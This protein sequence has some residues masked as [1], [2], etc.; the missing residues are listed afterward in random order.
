M[1][2]DSP[3]DR[4]SWLPIG[5]VVVAAA[6]LGACG[7]GMAPAPDRRAETGATAIAPDPRFDDVRA[8]LERL[9]TEGGIPSVVVAVAKDGEIL[10]Q[11]GFGMA[12]R[13]RGI[14]ATADIPYS[15]A[16][17][18][19]AVTST[20]VMML[21]EQGRMD[22]DAPL[23]TYLGG[24]R[25]AGLAADTRGVTARRAMSHSAG[26]PPHFRMIYPGEEVPPPEQTLTRYGFV[27][28][29]P[30]TRFMYS[31]IGYRALDVAISNASGQPYGEFLRRQLFLPLGM[32][33][34]GLNL[35]VDP[36]WSSRVAARYDARREPLRPYTTDHPGSGDV[37]ASAHDVL[38][39]AMLHLGTLLPR[40]RALLKQE[41]LAEMH[42]VAGRPE[43]SWGLG[44]QLAVDRG[45]RV[46]E[47]GGGQPGVSTQLS[48]YPD[49]ELAI[50]VLSNVS[51]GH[52]YD[53]SRRIAAAVLPQPRQAAPASAPPAA[54]AAPRAPS[55]FAGTWDGT[56]TTLD[57][58]EPVVLV[59]QP[60]GDV[61]V[62]IGARLTSLVNNLRVS[63]DGLEGSFHGILDTRDTR[64]HPHTVGFTLWPA[65]DEITGLLTASV[66]DPL[67][68][69]SSFVRLHRRDASGLDDYV[70]VYGH[71]ENDLRRITREGDRL[72]SQRGGGPRYELDPFG[73][74]VFLLAG[75]E[76]TSL[77]FIRENGRV[78]EVEVT[79]A[80]GA[81]GRAR[82]V[83]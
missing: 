11:E 33:R 50:V 77:R 27:A 61:H 21:N 13:E 9:V 67:L 63:A 57:R 45:H 8:H 7:V 72:Y 28:Y 17:I 44:W 29:P 64:R 15:L 23:E 82:R 31:N 70:G 26:L 25:F 76:G 5:G 58:E 46:V 75:A 60:N 41:T 32:T 81:S 2:G 80:S 34:S 4:N 83:E 78:V 42:R 51:G 24:I 47:H 18:N 22:L 53:V 14:A 3:A 30:G 65:G 49:E 16:S 19:K 56:L 43:W 55:D 38:R 59:F 71:G 35:N 68:V 10:W 36:A 20:A 6:L 66:S 37:W 54:A 62:R 79:P 1:P 73:A 52:A 74:D 39:F 48:L 12:D 40:Q 69:L